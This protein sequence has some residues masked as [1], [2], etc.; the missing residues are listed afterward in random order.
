MQFTAAIASAILLFSV[1]A[2]AAPVP[3]LAGEGAAS[4]SIL[5]STDNATGFGVK[6]A[7]DNTAALISKL[8]GGATTAAP[9]TPPAPRSKVRRQ[10]AGE[11]A[12]ADSVLSDTDNASGYSIKNVE[13]NVAALITS[14]KG[15][16]TGSV[17]APAGGSGSPPPPPPPHKYRRQADKISNGFKAVGNAAGLNVVTQPA[18]DTGDSL[19]G[20]LTN[21]AA[22]AGA[23]IGNTEESTLEGAT[24]D[25]PKFRRQAD[26]ISDGFKAIGNAAGLNVVTQPI[27]DTGDSVDG[28]LT[29]AAANAGAA[30]GKTEEST[31]EGATSTVPK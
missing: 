1:G 6:N 4:D 22:K 27:G 31:L 7:E 23:S 18:G 12:A 13:D 21:A 29:S 28:T 9:A 8:K 20:T 10:L 25:T 5:S 2:L 24:S 15:G 11:G 30:I 16:S 19:D 26:K 14:V 17:A 3:Q